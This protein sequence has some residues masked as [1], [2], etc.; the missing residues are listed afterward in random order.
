VER[1]PILKG[2]KP[3]WKLAVA[4][5]AMAAA[6]AAAAKAMAAAAAAVVAANLVVTINT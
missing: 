5:A 2:Y 4:V 6:V 3:N 1:F